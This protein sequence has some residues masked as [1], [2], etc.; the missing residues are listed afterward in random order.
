MFA[1]KYL[2]QFLIFFLIFFLFVSPLVLVIYY[3]F[4]YLALMVKGVFILTFFLGRYNGSFRRHTHT[5]TK[6]SWE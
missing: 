4:I 1:Y 3:S 2:L 5:I 6:R